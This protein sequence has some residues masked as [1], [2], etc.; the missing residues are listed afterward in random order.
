MSLVRHKA[1]PTAATDSQTRSHPREKRE[2]INNPPDSVVVHGQADAALAARTGTRAGMDW[3]VSIPYRYY[4]TPTPAFTGTGYLTW[5]LETSNARRLDAALKTPKPRAS[6]TDTLSAPSPTGASIHS[7]PE[8]PPPAWMLC[9]GRYQQIAWLTAWRTSHLL[10][11]QDLALWTHGF[12]NEIEG[13]ISIRG[14]CRRAPSVRETASPRSAADQL[15]ANPPSDAASLLAPGAEHSTCKSPS[16]RYEVQEHLS[17]ADMEYLSSLEISPSSARKLG[18]FRLPARLG[19]FWSGAWGR[20]W[21]VHLVNWITALW[22]QLAITK[23][24]KRIQETK[25]HHLDVDEQ[26]HTSMFGTARFDFG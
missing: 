24:S 10:R 11:V 9:A 2:N 12:T 25:I 19:I 3:M 22:H 5:Q 7:V 4:C 23:Q 16:L 17:A 21:H 18:Q 20:C 8:S 15:G 26:P 1:R 13:R 14:Q 6:K